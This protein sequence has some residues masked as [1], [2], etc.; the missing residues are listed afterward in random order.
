MLIITFSVVAVS[1]RKKG[2]GTVRFRT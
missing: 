2:F 1:L